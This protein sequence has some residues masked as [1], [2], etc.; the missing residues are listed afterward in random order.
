MGFGMTK[1]SAQLAEK[2]EQG[3]DQILSDIKEVIT[4]KIP[5]P[6][7]DVLELTEVIEEVKAANESKPTPPAPTPLPEPIA[8]AT[9]EPVKKAPAEQTVDILAKLDSAT[10]QPQMQSFVSTTQSP[11]QS[12]FTTAN[13]GT[14]ENIIDDA[15]AATSRQ[16]L[17]NFMKM[18]E[19]NEIDTLKLRSGNTV[20]DIIIELIKPQLSDWLNKNLPALVTSVVEKEIKKI[21]P[22][23]E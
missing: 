7:E 11:N 8:T 9:F 22:K 15:V 10:P 23:D 3:I 2:Q 19:K 6:Q 4:N 13:S 5:S 1:E 14:I 17:K 18:T 21:V 12:R 20:E 16:T